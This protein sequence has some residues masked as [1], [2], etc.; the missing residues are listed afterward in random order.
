MTAITAVNSSAGLVTAPDHQPAHDIPTGCD[1]LRSYSSPLDKIALNPQPL[2][3]K[4]GLVA[5]STRW[6]AVAINPQPL[7]PKESLVGASHPW[8]AVALNPQPLPPKEGREDT[9]SLS[10]DAV[11]DDQCGTAPRWIDHIPPVPPHLDQGSGFENT[12]GIIIIG[13]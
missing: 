2:P 9:A 8:D 7:P 11:A 12:H 13:G 6:D 10:I 4:E 3:P 5:A 1:A